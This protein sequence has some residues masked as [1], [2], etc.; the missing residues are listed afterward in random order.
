MPSFASA[1]ELP[2]GFWRW[3]HVDPRFEWADRMSG[4]LVVVPEFLDKFEALRV[5]VRFALPISSGYRTPAHNQVVSHTGPEGPH[6]TGRACDIKL[7]GER[8]L[9]VLEAARSFGFTG[10]G[11]MQAGSMASRYLHLD[12][13][14]ATLTRPRPFLWTY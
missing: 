1:A 4:A 11:V 14:E 8:A 10:I 9:L 6:T 13:L 2:P 3:P 5:A 12:D 7:Y